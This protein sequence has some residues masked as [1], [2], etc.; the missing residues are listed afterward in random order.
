MMQREL[1]ALGSAIYEI[2]EWK[3]PYA[4]VADR[5]NVNIWA[6]VEGGTMPQLS[7]DNVARDIILG[8]WE[9][10]YTSSAHVSESLEA[11]RNDLH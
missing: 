10:R 4:D 9:N 2:T 5:M 3:C 6:I 8:C 11:L 7:E 1:Y